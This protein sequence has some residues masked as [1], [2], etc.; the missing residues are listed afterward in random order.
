[1]IAVNTAEYMKIYHPSWVEVN[2]AHVKHNCQTVR[3]IVG[4]DVIICAV[5]KADAYG[6]GAVEVSKACIEA[7]AQY[8]AVAILSEA[9]ALREAGVTV[10]ILIMGWTSEE[11]FAQAIEHDICLSIFQMEKAKRLNQMALEQGKK[12]VVHLKIDTGMSRLGM[13]ADE[14]GLQLAEAVLRMEGISVEAIFSHFSKGDEADKTFAIEQL[15]KFWWFTEALEQR[16]GVHI[17]IRHMAASAGIIDI[18]ESHFDMVRPGIMMYGYQPSDEMHNIADL[19]PVLSWK[20]RVAH[21]KTLSP[22]CLI[23]YNGSFE[24]QKETLVA[25]IPV[26]Y[27][28]GYNRLQSNNGYVICQGKKLPI[29]GKICMDQFMVDASQIPDL[30]TGDDVI[31]LG[32]AE[33]VSITVTEMAKHWGTIEHEVTC[34]IA[35]RVPRIYID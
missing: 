11:V 22:G 29:I 4:D 23:G 25:T 18:P 28:D 12:A 1:M 21:V 16:S 8:L 27:G 19:K 35:A 17:P 5:V 7:G 14:T 10:P 13:Q 6:H 24:L 2:L 34:G 31:L 3:N 33:G 26:G 9:I 15:E 32:E 30:K 20:A